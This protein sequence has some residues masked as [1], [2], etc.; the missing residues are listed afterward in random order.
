MRYSNFLKIFLLIILFSLAGCLESKF[1]LSDQSRLPKWFVVPEGRDRKD[2]SVKMELYS[3]FTGGKVIFKLFEKDN[4]FHT[5]QYEITTDT[6]PGIRS[7][8]ISSQPEGIEQ[9]Y[10]RYKIITVNGIT[11]IVELRKREPVFYMADDP[12]V[13][14]ELG[15]EQ[16]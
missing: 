10:P 4:F 7:V 2:F 6:Q 12:N 3:T 5:Q 9:G 16:R 13:W 14:K 8:Q 11:D 15:V 1:R